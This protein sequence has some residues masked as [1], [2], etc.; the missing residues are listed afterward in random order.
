VPADRR[1]AIRPYPKELE[2]TLVLPGGQELFLRPIRPEDEPALQGLFARLSKE[3]IRLRFLHAMKILSHDMAARLTRIDY[4]REMALVLT[5][6]GVPAEPMLY[7][8]VRLAADPDNRRAEFAILIR[9]DFTGMGLGPMLMRRIID[10]ARQRGIGE[11][12]GDVLV[13]N[14]PMLK[15]CEAFGFKKKYDPREPDVAIVTLP[16]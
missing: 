12:F 15:L 11:L 14:R 4:D 3:E 6:P 13:D 5:D 2:E 1:L 9:R 8:V 16:L 7:G 10:Y